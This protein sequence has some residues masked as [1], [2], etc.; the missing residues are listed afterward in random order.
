MKIFIGF[1]LLVTNRGVSGRPKQRWRRLD[2]LEIVYWN[3]GAAGGSLGYRRRPSRSAYTSNYKYL[4]IIDLLNLKS[5]LK[6]IC[7]FL[8]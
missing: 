7:I 6:I 2:S 4:N 1:L 5:S 8:F 3:G